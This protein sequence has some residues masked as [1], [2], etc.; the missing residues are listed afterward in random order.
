LEKTGQARVI[1]KVATRRTLIHKVNELSPQLIVIGEDLIG[2]SDSKSES[3][4]EWEM[5]IEAIRQLSYKLRI[6][7]ICDRPVDDIFLTKL[8]TFNITDI[9]HEG[10]LPEGYIR[11][12]MGEPSFKNIVK[13]RGKVEK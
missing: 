2:E 4:E 13:F 5:V 6:V 10:K 11:Q 12:I 7:F 8:T 1:T 3:E 9:F